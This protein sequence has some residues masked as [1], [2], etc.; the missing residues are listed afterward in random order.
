MPPLLRCNP[1]RLPPLRYATTP[2]TPR[3]RFIFTHATTAPPRELPSKISSTP[4]TL[5]LA[6]RATSYCAASLLLLHIF[7]THVYD[8]D[9]AWGISMLPTIASSG[10]F[11]VLSRHYR[12]GRDITVGNVVSFRH[13]SKIGEFAVKRVVGMEGDF[14][15]LGTPGPGGSE[16]GAIRGARMVQVPAGHCWVVGDNLTWSRDSRIFG[17]LPLASIT[18]K[19]VRLWSWRDGW[20][21]LEQ[22]LSPAFVEDGAVD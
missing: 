10:E 22:G 20:R 2:L 16:E 4:S 18:G 19:V 7:S 15:V 1:W 11:V 6:I 5:N 12:R 9:P 21:V 14:V 17:A 3:P 13:P 8:I